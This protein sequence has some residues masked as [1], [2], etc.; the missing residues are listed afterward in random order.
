MFRCKTT[1]RLSAIAILVFVVG[2]SVNAETARGQGKGSKGNG[3]V[4]DGTSTT[5]PSVRYKVDAI[6]TPDNALGVL[7]TRSTIKV[8]PQVGMTGKG[9]THFFTINRRTNSTISIK[10]RICFSSYRL[11]GAFGPLTGSTTLVKWSGPWINRT[12]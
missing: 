11:A 10:W 8:S 4:D 6:P 3:G 12:V 9:V 5:L 1:L 2:M 7:S